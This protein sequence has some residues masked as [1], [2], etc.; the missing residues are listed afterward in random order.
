MG[1]VLTVPP[2]VEPLTLD[3]AKLHV[4]VDGTTED[5]LITSLIVAA[6]MEAENRAGVGIITQT[7]RETL[8]CFPSYIT[9]YGW[10]YGG[11]PDMFG[12]VIRLSRG[13]VQSITSIQYLDLGGQ[14]QTLSSDIYVLESTPVSDEISLAFGKIWPLIPPQANAIAITYVVGY[15]DDAVDVP[16]DL[17]AA[18]KLRVEDL[19]RNRGV[20]IGESAAENAAFSAL[21]GRFERTWLR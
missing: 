16:P 2:S 9:G 4:R 3:D 8:S 6:R 19:Y 18:L 5:A 7:W 13:P 21:L 1:L 11:G 15:A 14:T 17:V 20:Q 10:E 12:D